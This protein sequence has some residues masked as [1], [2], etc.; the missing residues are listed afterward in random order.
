MTMKISSLTI[1][2]LLGVVS[3]GINGKKPNGPTY[4]GTNPACTWYLD[5]VDDNYTCE[6]IESQWDLSHEVFVS[7]VSQSIL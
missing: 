4:A 6:N 2:P 3:A 5:L 7:W 1:F